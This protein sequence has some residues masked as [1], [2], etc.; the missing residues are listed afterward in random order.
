MTLNRYSVQVVKEQTAHYESLPEV[1]DPASLCCLIREALGLDK[2]LQEEVHIIMFNAK[3]KPIGSALIGMGGLTTCPASLADIFR[4]AICK[5][6][7][8][9]CLTHN[10]P[11]GETEP[12]VQDDVLTKNAIAAGK[13]LGIEVVD[14]IICADGGFHS[15]RDARPD[16]FK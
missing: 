13:I 14:H 8:A 5:G 15:Y 12:S 1:T 10:H 2:K 9:I 3:M 4:P 6:A 7:Y 11:S 16:M